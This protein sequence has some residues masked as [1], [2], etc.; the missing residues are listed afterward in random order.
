MSTSLCLE[1]AL[2]LTIH[3]KL[4]KFPRN[5]E[6]PEAEYITIGLKK[7]IDEMYQL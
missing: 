3:P 7:Q 6:L 4:L 1:V 5:Q 2:I